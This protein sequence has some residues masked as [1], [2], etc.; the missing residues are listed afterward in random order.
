M[1]AEIQKFR[2][3]GWESETAPSLSVLSPMKRQIKVAPMAYTGSTPEGGVEGTMQF[4][5]TFYLFPRLMEL[6]KY[7]VVDDSGETV[8]FLL[9]QPGAISKP[10]PNPWLQSLQEPMTLVAE[11][12]FQP[13]REEIEA[14]RDVRVHLTTV[15]KYVQSYMSYN[16]IATLEGKHD[17]VIVI[18]GHH[19][20]VEGSPGANDNAASDEASS[21]DQ[22]DHMGRA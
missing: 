5:G 2:Y 7:A 14:G 11:K 1:R 12:E 3:L 19:D 22:T 17:D 9:V 15:G 21:H 10:I 20:S 4:Y 18:G 16:V 13:I 8:A 6:P